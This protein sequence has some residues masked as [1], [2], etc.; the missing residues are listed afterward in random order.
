VAEQDV[1]VERSGAGVEPPTAGLPRRTGFEDFRHNCL[2]AGKKPFAGN[3][4]ASLR[5]GPL[6]TSTSGAAST[7][8]TGSTRTSEQLKVQPSSERIFR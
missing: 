8:A 1:S 5:A 2:Y 7:T 3:L 4:R 6:A